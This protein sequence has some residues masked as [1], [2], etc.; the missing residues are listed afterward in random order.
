MKY[1]WV[2]MEL[3]DLLEADAD[4]K[5]R[6]E[7]A[8]DDLAQYELEE[9]NGITTLEEWLDW[10]NEYLYWIPN[11]TRKAEILSQNMI[12][13]Y[14][15][16]NHPL[17]KEVV[18]KKVSILADWM[19]D[20]ANEIGRFLDTVES[21]TPDTLD[22]FY[23]SPKFK[24]EEYI[25][26]PSEWKTFNQFFARQIK[27]GYRPI[28]GLCDD[29]TIV[30]VADSNFRGYWSINKASEITV[31]NIRWSIKELLNN[32]PYEER[33]NGGTFMHAYLNTTDYHRYHT[34]LAGQVIWSEIIPG[35]V[36]L[37]TEI[38]YDRIKERYYVEQRRI[39]AFDPVGYQFTQTRGLL[40]LN[41]PK[42]L[43]AV[44]PVG[45]GIVSSVTITAEPGK[46]L[47]KGQEFGYFQFGGSDYI[48]LFEK[49][50]DVEFTADVDTHY[51]QGRAIGYITN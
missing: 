1:N 27:P 37:T 9:F 3:M 28:D 14:L 38:I 22:T 18:D 35:H 40:I 7:K 43:V 17:L 21:L 42:G 5:M 29:V 44:I 10:C 49:H 51:N 6:F 48:M 13:F 16:F 24:L 23:Q 36:V 4:Y 8:I 32:N 34:P 33:F 25:T 39:D 2:I 30:S 47:H 11:E 19:V 41:T 31:K 15:V 12:C 20:Y 26:G 50:M 45:M 46:Y